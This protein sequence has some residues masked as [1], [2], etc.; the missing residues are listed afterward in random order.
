MGKG[1]AT[2]SLH[3]DIVWHWDMGQR[4]I[5]AATVG[6]VAGTR[7]AGSICCYGWI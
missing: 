2:P 7:A 5:L 6:P 1:E 3:F 4:L